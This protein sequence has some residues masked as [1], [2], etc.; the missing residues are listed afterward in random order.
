[1]LAYLSLYV[2]SSISLCF[3]IFLAKRNFAIGKYRNRV[4][5]YIA[6]TTLILL[7]LEFAT[8]LL[9][10]SSSPS[11]VI[12]HRILNII[13]FSLSP[14]VPF[15]LLFFLKSSIKKSFYIG[16]AA[17]P[18]YINAIVCIASYET[19]W[20]FSV[21]AQN[22]Y[23]RGNL[24]ML[25]TLV[26][27]IYYLAVFKTLLSNNT[28]DEKRDRVIIATIYSLPIFAIIIQI[29]FSKVLLIWGS[30]S[31][32]LLLYYIYVCD[33][34]FTYDVQTGIKNRAAFQKEMEKHEKSNE[35]ITILVFDI[36]N[37]KEIND[38]FGHRVGDLIIFDAAMLIK[39]AFSKVGQTYRIGGDEFC[40]LCKETDIDL[41]EGLL[42]HTNDLLVNHNK[43]G[44][45]R[46]WLSYGYAT[47][48][49]NSSENIY[50][51]FSRADNAM[52]IHKAKLKGDVSKSNNI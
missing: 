46:I 1:M 5:I 27:A 14:L 51:L 32:S 19:G 25:P 11:L 10:T 12:L 9:E 47:Q 52:Y 34:Q 29:L 38:T 33:M 39:E 45:Q 30:V 50:A 37:L 3:T 17:I 36:N 22:Q 35:A 20:I 41:V 44:Q 2:F 4:Y 28:E 26:F 8:I 6:V 42:A 21:D 49:K 7:A 18:L 15:I 13:G 31:I 43:N 48:D 16:I 40:V 24:F 23:I